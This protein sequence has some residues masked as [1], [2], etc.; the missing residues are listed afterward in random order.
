MSDRIALDFDTARQHAAR[1]GRVRTDVVRAQEAAGS[2]DLAG[3]AFGLMCSFLVPP[4]VAVSAVAVGTIS[5]VSS[6]L[7]RAERELRA[8]VADFETMEEDFA[9]RYRQ[10]QAEL[11]GRR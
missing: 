3:G 2:L 6:L 9:G 8:V 11:G 7:G 4:A 5:S 10:L 1:V